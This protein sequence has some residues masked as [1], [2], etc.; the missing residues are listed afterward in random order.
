M[1]IVHKTTAA[2]ILTAIIIKRRRNKKVNRRIWARK[3]ILRRD[4]ENT[5]AN[6]IKELR[7]ERPDEFQRHFRVSPEQFDILL[8]KVAP[9]IRKKDTHMRKS[10][11][12]ETRLAITLRFL[13]SG[14]SFRSLMLLFRVAHNTISCIVSTTCKAIYSALVNDYL[15]VRM[16]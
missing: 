4:L 15:K 11:S 5:D 13:S 12:A 9:A 8:A 6:F 2:A 3:W 7:N 1:V 16:S 14:D 10:V